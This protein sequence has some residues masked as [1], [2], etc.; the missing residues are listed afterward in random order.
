MLM[1][2]AIFL[3]YCVL[4][5]LYPSEYPS[6]ENMTLEEKVGQLLIAHFHGESAN[7]DAR[8]LIEDACIGGIIY[9]EWANGLHSPQQVQNL[10]NELQKL[11][12]RNR[13]PIALFISTDQEGGLVSTLKSGFTVFPGNWALGQT[14]DP[15]LAELSSYAM[16]KEMLAVGINVDFSPVV[17]VNCNP[18]NPVI[19]I[20]SFSD[21]VE[22]VA[23]HAKSALRGYHQAHVISTLKHFP[24]HGDVAFDSH[25]YLPIVNKSKEE[26]MR[27]ELYPYQQLL[28]NT[29]MVMAAH[30]SIPSLDPNQCAT[31]SKRILEDLLRHEMGFQGIVIS[32]SLLMEGLF[33]NCSSIEEAALRAFNAGCDILLLGGKQ[34]IGQRLNFELTVKDVKRIHRS[35]VEAVKNGQIDK[36]RVDAS[37]TR[38]LNLKNEYGLFRGD[39]P[40]ENEIVQY[41]N[42]KENQRL[43]AHIANL[44]VEMVKNSLPETFNFSEMKI[45]ILVPSAVSE[46]VRKSTLM[47]LGKETQF[48]R[49]AFQKPTDD[50]IRIC[51]ALAKQAEV[52]IVCSYNAWQFP[53]QNALIQSILEASLHTIVISLKDPHDKTLFPQASAQITTCSPTAFSLEAAVLRLQGK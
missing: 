19:G 18:R 23:A 20:R 50:E 51:L 8:I 38:I 17:D 28:K 21:S 27:I 33:A 13:Y 11:V 49:F 53:E 10:S 42:T 29:E 32:D 36:E 40:A 47:T 37:V 5:P 6:L 15:H 34:L 52:V 3:F 30:I 35:L 2:S 7:E 9:Y 24:G 31:F 41:V 4:S 1:R 39:F 43:A 12:Q 44:S 26:L 48:S 22:V 16:G 25:E 45:A 46:L 14:K